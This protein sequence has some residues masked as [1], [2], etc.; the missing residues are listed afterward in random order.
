M[1]ASAVWGLKWRNMLWEKNIPVGSKLGTA[2]SEQV[3]S[4][5]CSLA[6]KHEMLPVLILNTSPFPL[7]SLRLSYFL[8]S[9]LAAASVLLIS[10]LE[11]FYCPSL[12]P[13]IQS[14]SMHADFFF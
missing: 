12:T 3:D 14:V 6:L 11:S 9:S 8:V 1:E 10:E 4:P 5:L 2:G 7:T 13:L